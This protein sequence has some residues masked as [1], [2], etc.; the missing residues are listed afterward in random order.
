MSVNDVR[1]HVGTQLLKLTQDE[2]HPKINR[3]VVASMES[4]GGD[5]YAFNK[6]LLADALAME[7]FTEGD[8]IVSLMFLSPGKHAGEDGDIAEIISKAVEGN[9]KVRVHVTDLV[10]GHDVVIDILEDRYKALIKGF[11]AKK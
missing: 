10:G 7:G 8:V 5:Q 3:F 11:T 6:P 1:N 4:R 9:S 2:S